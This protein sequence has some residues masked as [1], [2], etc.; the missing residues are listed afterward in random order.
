MSNDIW[1][2]HSKTVKADLCLLMF[3]CQPFIEK[4]PWMSE[5]LQLFRF[6]RCGSVVPLSSCEWPSPFA[7]RNEAAVVEMSLSSRSLTFVRSQLKVPWA[8]GGGVWE[9]RV[10]LSHHGVHFG[11]VL[12]N[13][14]KLSQHWWASHEH[15][16]WWFHSTA[17]HLYLI[18][19]HFITDGPSRSFGYAFSLFSHSTYFIDHNPPRHIKPASSVSISFISLSFGVW[20]VWTSIIKSEIPNERRFHCFMGGPW[21]R[22]RCDG[23]N[24]YIYYHLLL[25]PCQPKPATNIQTVLS[26]HHKWEC[27]CILH[28]MSATLPLVTS[29]LPAGAA[30]LPI[31][32]LAMYLNA[33]HV[34]TLLYAGLEFLSLAHM[35]P[36]VAKLPYTEV[37]AEASQ[38]MNQTHWTSLSGAFS[39][40]LRLSSLQKGH[41]FPAWK[42]FWLTSL[43]ITR[44]PF[45]EDDG[46][47]KFGFIKATNHRTG[48]LPGLAGWHAGWGITLSCVW[49]RKIVSYFFDVGWSTTKR[50]H[51]VLRTVEP[52]LCTI[53]PPLSGRCDIRSCYGGASK[54]V[55]DVSNIFPAVLGLH[56]F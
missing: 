19:C 40:G 1:P 4:R 42:R 22:L 55:G 45:E 5:R 54:M 21:P 23:H 17:S 18:S 24:H 6:S 34:E 8:T 51:H 33:C 9:G 56:M 12:L 25:L 49:R 50:L 32:M 30:V 31:S 10:M 47:G 52:P 14:S 43:L 26:F 44:E 41:L 11:I 2:W 20:R 7:G 28:I 46:S 36:I 48:S 3:L 39:R 38:I 35:S 13:L 53:P 15:G 29:V 16:R 37:G 27:S